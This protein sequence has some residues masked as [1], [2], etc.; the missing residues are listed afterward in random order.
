MATQLRIYT[1]KA[2]QLDAWIDLFGRGISPL[3]AAHG[4]EIEAWRSS[5]TDQFVWIV[6]REGSI[7]EFE[8][9]DEAYYALPEHKPLH[10][11]ALGYLE[12]GE[13]WF[14]EQVDA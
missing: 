9:A 14:L 6:R 4:F 10:V 11:E 13:S 12:K 2:G 8:A 5:R 1:M 7:E 3:R